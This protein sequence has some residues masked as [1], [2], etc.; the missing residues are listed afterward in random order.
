MLPTRKRNRNLSRAKA[1]P[2]IEF[3]ENRITPDVSASIVAASL[4]STSPPDATIGE[5]VRVRVVADQNLTGNYDPT[6]FNVVA[7]LPGGLQYLP[8]TADIALMSQHGIVSTLDP[9]NSGGLDVTG[10]DPTGVHPSFLIPPSAITTDPN[11]G[12]MTFNTGISH[13]NDNGTN[14]DFIIIEFNALVKNVASNQ[15]APPSDL[16]ANFQLSVGGQQV[17][18]GAVPISVVEPSITNLSKTV[19]VSGNTSATFTLTFTNSGASTAYDVHVLDNIPAGLTLNPAMTH[20]VG[21]SGLTDRSNGQTLDL[22]LDSVAPGGSVTISYQTAINVPANVVSILNNVDLDYSSLPGTNGPSPNPTGSITPGSPGTATGERDGSGGVNDYTQSIAAN[23]L[24]GNIPPATTSIHGFVFFDANCNGHFSMGTDSPIAG[25]MI[26]LTDLNGNPV[27]DVNGNIVGNATSAA[28]GSYQFVNLPVGD[29][30]VTELPPQPLFNGAPTVEGITTAGNVNGVTVGVALNSVITDIDLTA[31][32]ETYGN[33]FAECPPNVG[34]ITLSGNVY[35]DNNKD[36][37]LDGGDTPVGGVLIH[38]VRT[39]LPG[40]PVQVAQIKTNNLGQYFFQVDSTGTYEVTEDNVSGAVKESAQPGTVNGVPT[41]TATAVD[42][43]SDITLTSGDAGINY[44]FA[45][46]CNTPPPNSKQQLLANVPGMTINSPLATSPSFANIDKSMDMPTP[47]FVAVGATAGGG[48]EVRVFDFTNGKELYDFYAYAPNFTGG[49]NVAVGDV[50]GDGIPD[51]ITAPMS[52]GAPEIKVFDGKTGA[53]IRE[54]MAYSPAFTG[55]VNIAVA[56]VNGDG[57]DDIITAPAS[58]GGPDVRVFDGKTGNMIA[59]FFAYAP[60]FTGGVRITA[61]DFNQDGLADIVT[62]A[63]PGGGP[64]VKIFN[65]ATLGA[66]GSTPALINQFFA[67]EPTYTGGIYVAAN[68]GREG[69]FTGDGKTD[70]VVSRG[71]GVGEVKVIDGSSFATVSDFDVFGSSL[72]NNGA[73]IS[74]FD[75]NGDGKADIVAGTGGGKGAFVRI[76]NGGTL[77]ELEFFQ[78]FNPAFLG[79]ANVAAG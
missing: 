23:V 74:V 75:L 33:N 6:N 70:L 19:T 66:V 60:N 43:L 28:D 21:G 59:N 13:A 3:L 27:K 22:T 47:D 12:A 24:I 32:Q 65:S 71:T 57:I 14:P 31:G 63:G 1:R 45:L 76:V 37:V 46:I 56:D 38:L 10:S 39:D 2:K 49:V 5:I 77:N 4:A 15:G 55:G 58:G 29:Y 17:A 67:F 44:N 48:P 69:D 62:G 40:G 51:I 9:T 42:V 41:G 50:N 18:V 64:H 30:R 36:N 79:G 35:C 78:A 54:F 8:G 72:N 20:V 73:H 68:A 26:K 34:S 52:G 25:V 16:S 7:S 61:G 53:L 11:T